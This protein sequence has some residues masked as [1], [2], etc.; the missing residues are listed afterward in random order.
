MWKQLVK[1][2]CTEPTF[3]DPADPEVLAM[4]ETALSLTFPSQLRS[5]LLETNGIHG[6][7]GLGLVWSLDRI[8]HDNQEFRLEPSYKDLYMPFD[9]LLFFADAGNGDQFAFAIQAGEIRRDDIFVWDHEDDSRR[10]IAPSLA[11]Y[12]ERWLSGKLK[13]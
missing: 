12:L 2:H 10:W 9:C 11:E 6:E 5:C 8:V 13:V 7:Y 4:A 3:F 1:Q